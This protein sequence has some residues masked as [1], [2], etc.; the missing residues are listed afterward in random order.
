MLNLIG[1]LISLSWK[2]LSFCLVI[3]VFWALIRSG[4]DTIRDIR[5]TIVMGIRVG[6]SKIQKWLFEK[7]KEQTKEEPKQEP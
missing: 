3:N 7:Y 2:M 5:T 6:I 4:K 1:Q